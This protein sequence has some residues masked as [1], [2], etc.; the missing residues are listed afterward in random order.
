MPRHIAFLRAINV[1]GHV[2]K[3]DALRELFEHIGHSGVE[4]FIASGNVIF[5]SAS[6]N[7]G[8]LERVIEAKL[9]EALGYEVATFIRSPAE[10]ARIGRCRPF[11]G[12]KSS[13]DGVLYVGFLSAKPAAD[14]IRRLRSF[15]SDVDELR[16]RGRELYWRL[17]GNFRD[18][19]L[20]GARL[21]KVLG[22]KATV[23]NITT[24]SKLAA[25]YA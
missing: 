2:V 12:A 20:S 3:M 7:A 9:K 25:K 19:K 10:L 15:E 4:T 8:A 5:E 18:S 6:R 11:P 14:A 1:G 24:V 23:R 22:V 21:E 13:N 16:V 17:R